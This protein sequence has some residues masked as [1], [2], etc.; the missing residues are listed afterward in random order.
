M[1]SAKQFN[2]NFMLHSRDTWSKCPGLSL[3]VVMLAFCYGYFGVESLES[4][5]ATLEI[6]LYILESPYA[7]LCH[8]FPLLFS[9]FDH[10]IRCYHQALAMNM[11]NFILGRGSYSSDEQ[12]NADFYFICVS[13]TG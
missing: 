2:C 10:H 12:I 7:S 6:S 1:N 11:K 5:P 4:T 3:Y 9:S 8:F 13:K